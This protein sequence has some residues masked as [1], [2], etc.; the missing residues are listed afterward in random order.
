AARFRKAHWW[1]FA[2]PAEDLY[3]RLAG[4]DRCLVAAR[5]SKFLCFAFQP[6]GRVFANTV[7]VIPNSSTTFLGILQSRVHEVWVRE[8]SSTLEDRLSYSTS[9]SFETF[10]LPR[11]DPQL[12]IPLLETIGERLCADR[13]R[14]MVDTD[15]GLTKTYNHLKDP[16]CDDPRILALRTLHEEMDRAVLDAYGWADVAVPPF[17]I[18]TPDEER[19]LEQFKEAVIDRLFALNAARAEE[20]R[21]LGQAKPAKGARTKPAAKAKPAAR[22]TKKLPKG[23]TEAEQPDL[24][25]N[26]EP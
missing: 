26:E 9:D 25:D 10:P 7:V 20:E 5:V 12:V 19:A 1:R 24:F 14:Y 11:P 18:R 8:T 4:L 22:A 3:R 23:A 21:R 16:A 15:Q 2:G 6:I 17:C 13:A